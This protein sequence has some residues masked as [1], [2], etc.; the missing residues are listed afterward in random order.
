MNK[1]IKFID[2][3]R[4]KQEAIKYLK[5]YHSK[6]TKYIDNY[7]GEIAIDTDKDIHIGQVFVGNTGKDK[8]FITGLWVRDSYRGS[9]LGSKLLEDAIR[10]YNGVDL[11]V[12]KDN[13]V[14]VNMYKKHGFVTLKYDNEEYY[15]MKLKSKIDK[16]DVLEATIYE[17]KNNEPFYFYHIADKNADIDKLGL[18]PL[19]YFYDKK[20]YE[21]FDKYSRKYINRLTDGWGIYPGREG[22]SL[23][24]EEII[25]GLHKYREGGINRIYFFRYPPYTKLH[26]DIN[27]ILNTRY[28]YRININ[29]PKLKPYIKYIHWGY[30]DSHTDNEK[31]KRKWYEDVTVDK[32]FKQ[33]NPNKTPLF[34]SLW[35]ISIETT[36]GY[37]PSEFIEKV[38]TPNTIEDVKRLENGV[39]KEA[40]KDIA[41]AR[42]FV[43]DVSKLAKK[44]DA[45]YFIVTDGASG[46]LNN[47]N[48]AVKNARDAQIKW[49]K[50]HGFD[51]D[52]N[53]ANESSDFPNTEY[54]DSLEEKAILNRDDI[55]YNMDKFENGSNNI[56][57][58]FGYS[59]SGKSTLIKELC[60]RYDSYGISGDTFTMCVIHQFDENIPEK[61]S[62]QSNNFK[63]GKFIQTYL[64]TY[65]FNSIKY[66]SKKDM[67]NSKEMYKL[68][69][70]FVMWLE[71]DKNNRFII[72]GFQLFNFDNLDFFKDKSIIIKGTS[73]VTSYIRKQKRDL[74]K[75]ISWD[76]L[77]NSLIGM[78]PM[79][80]DHYKK[81]NNLEKII[82]ESMIIN[83]D[84]IYYNKDKF[85]SGEINLCFITGHSGSGKSTMA[86]NLADGKTVEY[87]ELD[88]VVY[89]KMNFTMEN[90]K[91][92]GDLIY[93]FFKGP[94]KKYYYT[95]EDVDN[96][97]I[98]PVGDNY[99]ELL[100]KDFINYS[101]RYTKSH[102]NKKYIIEGLWLLD[103]IEPSYLKDYAVY[104]K[105]TSL[106]ISTIR[107]ANRDSKY[108]K[109][110]GNSRIR[111]WI[112]RV[113]NIKNFATCE[114]DLNK[115][116]KYFSKLTKKE[117]DNTMAERNFQIM[118]LQHQMDMQA[119]QNNM[120][121]LASAQ[122]SES[123]TEDNISL[124]D[125]RIK[126]LARLVNE[127]NG[128]F[129][130]AIRR[131]IEIS[132]RYNDN[133]V[134]LTHD[135]YYRTHKN[136][137][138]LV[139][140]TVIHNKVPSNKRVYRVVQGT[141]D[142]VIGM[143]EFMQRIMIPSILKDDNIR[144]F[145]RSIKY[146]TIS[147]T[148]NGNNFSAGILTA[149]IKGFIPANE[150]TNDN[151]I[152]YGLPELKKYPM[153]DEKH[154]LS[155]IRFFN[156]VSMENEKELA[157]NIKKQM[158]KYGIKPDRVGDK[159]R[160]KKYLTEDSDIL[161]DID[162]RGRHVLVFDIG[163]VL[164]D[165]K[166]GTMRD[167]IKNCRLI[168][169]D[170]SD[171]VYDYISIK[172]HNHQKY[173]D[174]VESEI[175]YSFMTN[176]APRNI[177][178]YIPTALKA[179]TD[180]VYKLHYTD[181]LLRKLK[182]QGYKMYYLSNWSKWSR[183]VLVKNGTF[184][185]LKYFDGGIF[186]CDVALMKPNKAIYEELSKKYDIDLHYSIF[187]DD[188][189]ENVEAAIELGMK[190]VLWNKEYS[191]EMIYTL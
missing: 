141:D 8:N 94:G 139:T 185:F 145:V 138:P 129:Y 27:R 123:I 107:A 30:K 154:V 22:S 144:A 90:F 19:E 114:K 165:Y 36:Q 159:N 53:W 71:G 173:L 75:D 116:C 21:E 137:I 95:K 113:S 103:F 180:D 151:D 5:Q 62:L 126:K 160:L 80:I 45:N 69:Q 182:D 155:T 12:A 91:E 25:D 72:E 176:N 6:Y 140:A 142:V 157:K 134:W 133:N 18:V 58:I 41:T 125:K 111:A 70:D 177:K 11:T 187:F 48:P 3:S 158:K 184:D 85:D 63:G 47:G 179:M 49:E 172:F 108:E 164:V 89:N 31:L 66:G 87:Y 84:D 101:I 170:K 77:K 109:E 67:F 15:W 2:I 163:S 127:D 60:K 93:S 175:Y 178:K 13:K 64:N 150:S 131:D 14:A 152:P 106:L 118:N 102:K 147:P 65:G 167:A 99:E 130:R 7:D 100:I 98:K 149:T 81:L 68:F 171:E 10:K 161:M 4:N 92:Y 115:W 96:G 166:N 162:S 146:T 174:C 153:P 24:R 183:D 148:K 79:Y 120:M 186:S 35:H 73:V 78:I 54:M 50:E 191:A 59:G 110:M 135:K 86:R 189:I 143:T 181:D 23:T 119:H 82:D 156:Y 169:A 97:K 112:N 29:D 34:A 55:Y 128:D 32:Y 46:T 16:N 132:I 136:E 124:L 9:G 42:R 52:E 26:P 44:Y 33:F 104:I 56:L 17:G 105:G 61:Y 168:P 117:E 121:L 43:R 40:C 188:S 88:D 38:S 39:M 74:S 57:Y 37:I 51:P 1:N 122:L 28:V 83:T 190:G 76:K 20:M